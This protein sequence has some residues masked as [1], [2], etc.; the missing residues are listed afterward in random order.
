MI[1]FV[2]G[3][4]KVYLNFIYYILRS[5]KKK[6]ND[7]VRLVVHPHDGVP[8]FVPWFALIDLDIASSVKVFHEK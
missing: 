2:S 4:E 8:S 5:E 1:P 6:T 7:G 3:I